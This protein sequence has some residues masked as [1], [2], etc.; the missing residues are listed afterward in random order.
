MTCTVPVPATDATKGNQDREVL[1]CH[2][3]V[4]LTTAVW[5]LGSP[6]G[7][8]DSCHLI[9]RVRDAAAVVLPIRCGG[10]LAVL[11]SD[12]DGSAEL[13]LG[14]D[15][16]GQGIVITTAQLVELQGNASQPLD[17]GEVY[18]NSCA[19]APPVQG[20]TVGSLVLRR[21]CGTTAFAVVQEQQDCDD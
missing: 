7:A 2:E 15:S 8:G 4:A 19:G 12:R 5:L 13:V 6:D 20:E 14:S 18:S 9:Y 10:L 21:R 17:L 1:W 16:V 3:E 11:D